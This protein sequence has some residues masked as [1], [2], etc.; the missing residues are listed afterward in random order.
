MG[1]RRVVV[2]GLGT[3]NP[4]G[5][6]VEEYFSSLDRGVSGAALITSFDTSRFKT[7]FAC[8][9]KNDRRHRQ[10]HRRDNGLLRG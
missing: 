9:V 1:L 4:L 6:T 3:I 5:N 2:T 8:T 7:R 10:P